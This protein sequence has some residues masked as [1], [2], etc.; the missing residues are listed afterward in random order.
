MLLENY[1]FSTEFTFEV[2]VS[3]VDTLTSSCTK[4][5]LLNKDNVERIY[6]LLY[7]NSIVRAQ[8]S[9]MILCS[10]NYIREVRMHMDFLEDGGKDKFHKICNA[11]VCKNRDEDQIRD[12]FLRC[13]T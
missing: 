9:P 5:R 12:A 8:I 13:F 11:Y 7:D 1:V 6:G 4:H 2:E 3:K 10:K